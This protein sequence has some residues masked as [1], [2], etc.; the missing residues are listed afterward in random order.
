VPSGEYAHLD[1]VTQRPVRVERFT[2]ASAVDGWRYASE[3]FDEASA[4]RVGTVDVTADS[5]W[6]Q[7]RVQLAFGQWLIR[8]G[9]A[10]GELLWLRM[11]ADGLPAQG[12]SGSAK[13]GGLLGLSPALAICIARALALAVGERRRVQVAQL[14]AATLLPEPV[15]QEWSLVAVV[16]HPTDWH[17]LPVEQYDVS[18][19]GQAPLTW[20]LAGDVAL[21][22]PHVELADLDEPPNFHSGAPRPVE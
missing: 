5:R 13:A 17:A 7:A 3:I 22:G 19:A 1:P 18:V 10:A 12:L 20:Y 15:E 2:A 11:P 6:R 8:G 21:A 16:R 14:S 9:V 4:R